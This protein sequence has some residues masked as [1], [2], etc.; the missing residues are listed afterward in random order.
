M[1]AASVATNLLSFKIYHQQVLQSLKSINISSLPEMP[2]KLKSF[3]KR[4]FNLDSSFGISLFR[5]CLIKGDKSGVFEFQKTQYSI[6]LWILQFSQNF[7]R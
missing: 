5:N 6:L 2:R 4:S 1:Q 7:N 3:I